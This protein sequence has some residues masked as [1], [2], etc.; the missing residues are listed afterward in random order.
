M[1]GDT[2]TVLIGVLL[3]TATLPIGFLFLFLGDRG[4]ARAHPGADD[5]SA[6]L[7]Q[8]ERSAQV[9]GQRPGSAHEDLDDDNRDPDNWDQEAGSRAGRR[10]TS[11]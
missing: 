3:I 10:A 7:P 9:P 5:R 1:T 11:V 8:G 4:I 6:G 2:T